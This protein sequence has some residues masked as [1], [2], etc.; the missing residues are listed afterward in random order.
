MAGKGMGALIKKLFM[1]SA[2]SAIGTGT[3]LG[4]QGAI[5]P[6]SP[7]FQRSN[8]REAT[9]DES[10]NML[11]VDMDGSISYFAIALLA[12]LVLVIIVTI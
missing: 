10:K 11:K 1:S 3:V 2:S 7:T 4:L 8:L 9:V 6:E 5:A 12:L